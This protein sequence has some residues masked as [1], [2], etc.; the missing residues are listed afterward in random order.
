M[1]SLTLKSK[2]VI[3]TVILF[4]SLISLA[5]LGLKALR[6]AS[7]MD[8]IARINQL[9]KSTVNIV[10]Q[11]ELASKWHVKRRASKTTCHSNA[12]RK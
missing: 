1:H 9:M 4:L 10:N 7:E 8:N 2:I 3:F 12:Q 5:G 6:Q 11:F